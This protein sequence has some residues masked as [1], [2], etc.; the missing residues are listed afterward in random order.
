M[1]IN[2]TCEEINLEKH[3]I[4]MMVCQEKKKTQHVILF[5]KHFIQQFL[6]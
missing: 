1:Q 4:S 5:K 6:S 2:Y 3:Y